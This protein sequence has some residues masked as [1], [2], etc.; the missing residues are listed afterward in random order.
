MH[1]GESHFGSLFHATILF[2]I[3]RINYLKTIAGAV[4][5]SYPCDI[6][7]L[8]VIGVDGDKEDAKTKN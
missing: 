4:Y 1:I 2:L 3:F 5:Y 7:F 6:P 8:N